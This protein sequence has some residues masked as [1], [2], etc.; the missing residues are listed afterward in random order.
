[1]LRLL[2]ALVMGGASG[3]CALAAVGLALYA[4]HPSVLWVVQC[5]AAWGFLSGLACGG[6][7]LHFHGRPTP[8]PAAL[9]PD[10]LAS[11][12]RATLANAAAERQGRS[13]SAADRRPAPVPAAALA[14][15][16]AAAPA[17]APAPATAEVA[18]S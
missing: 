14:P 13:G 8:A 10:A 6:L 1:V 12:V 7:H 16:P 4:Q 3:A 15:E 11:L 2:L 9:P 17:P 5:F 18:T